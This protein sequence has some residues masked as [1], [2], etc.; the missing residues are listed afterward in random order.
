MLLLVL[1]FVD[2]VVQIESAQIAFVLF[3]C[4][5]A[6][7]CHLFADLHLERFFEAR[8]QVDRHQY[9]ATK[10]HIDRHS[11]FYARKKADDILAI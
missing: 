7:S 6:T 8:Q 11:V 2:S 10:N 3:E 1:D 9:Y 5:L 4:L